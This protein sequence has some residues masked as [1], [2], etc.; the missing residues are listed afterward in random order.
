MDMK[1]FLPCFISKWPF[2]DHL[3]S[4][5]T[6]YKSY[7]PLVSFKTHYHRL[8]YNFKTFI[9]TFPS[10]SGQFIY[11]IVLIMFQIMPLLHVTITLV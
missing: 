10:D 1:S 5:T 2:Q 7:L 8:A 9:V 6:N 4:I 3:P 11:I